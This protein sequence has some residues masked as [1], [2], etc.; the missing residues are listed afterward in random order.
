MWVMSSENQ[1]SSPVPMT[2]D[3]RE[4]VAYFNN[5]AMNPYES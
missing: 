3:G 2:S 4:A 5:C 1:V